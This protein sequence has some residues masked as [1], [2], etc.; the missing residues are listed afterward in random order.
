MPWDSEERFRIE[1]VLEMLRRASSEFEQL[2]AVKDATELLE[3]LERLKQ[4]ELRRILLAC[5]LI[6]QRRRGDHSGTERTP[7]GQDPNGH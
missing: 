7:F 3:E 6:E 5:V 1:S 2:A 4:P